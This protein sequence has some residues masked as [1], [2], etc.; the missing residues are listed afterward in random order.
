MQ[1]GFKYIQKFQPPKNEVINV[2]KYLRIILNTCF[3]VE[4]ADRI[5]EGMN[6]IDVWL[7]VY[8]VRNTLLLH[9]LVSGAEI[10]GQ[11]NG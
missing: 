1:N 8:H 10:L 6:H 9:S 2:M 5:G 11:T 3:L 7:V 4:G